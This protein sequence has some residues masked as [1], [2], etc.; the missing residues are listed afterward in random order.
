MAENRTTSIAA[1]VLSDGGTPVARVSTLAVETL[2]DGGGS[3]ARLTEIAVEVLMDVEEAGDHS[4]AAGAAVE[5]LSNGTDAVANVAGASVDVLSSGIDSTAFVAG[6][7]V[8]VMS[9]VALAPKRAFDGTE[10]YEFQ[11]A[12]LPETIYNEADYDSIYS[13]GARVANGTL[14]FTYDGFSGGTFGTNPNQ[15]ADFNWGLS[16]GNGFVVGGQDGWPAGAY[17]GFSTADGSYQFISG[18][19][20]YRS[21]GAWNGYWTM[22]AGYD[23]VVWAVNH[24]EFDEFSV[25]FAGGVAEI[26]FSP[27][28]VPFNYWSFTLS[29]FGAGDDWP[30]NDFGSE[31]MLKVYHS[32]LDGGDRRPTNGRAIKRVTVS[33]SSGI[34]SSAGAGND[35]LQNVVDGKYSGS[36]GGPSPLTGKSIA[37]QF[38]RV[39]WTS[40]DDAILA[41]GEYIQFSFPRKVVMREMVWNCG[42]SGEV[43]DSGGNPTIYGTWQWQ[44]SNASGSGYVNIGDPWHFAE[45]S[46]W[47]KS[48][49]PIPAPIADITPYLYPYWR[50]VLVEGPAFG[51]SVSGNIFQ[52]QFNLIDPDNQA[53]ILEI[54][55]SDDT[56]GVAPVVTI[57]SA[58]SPNEI[59]YSD[60]DSDVL[61]A[62]ITIV[63][64]AILSVSF[65]D[66]TGDGLQA[67]GSF[68]PTRFSQTMVVVKGR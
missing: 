4:F 46:N 52:I 7:V 41:A 11:F 54:A 42:G 66:D 1:E 26:T 19:K 22:Y 29:S 27:P 60:G 30:G 45:G 40:G 67:W 5:V 12:F 8:E 14:S 13:I 47:I 43:L 61:N 55:F 10:I 39:G 62:T 63:E 59:K 50:M 36:N 56:D 16:G 9:S 28:F 6:A 21:S 20:F 37:T 64:N 2:S 35:A 23:G 68:Y 33:H 18:V 65:S 58:G 17:V 3:T 57:G 53:P 38:K 34:E 49:P 48:P 51:G 44:A 24:L 32:V 15:L 25:G 31:I